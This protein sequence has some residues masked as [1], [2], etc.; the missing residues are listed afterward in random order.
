MKKLGYNYLPWQNRN[1]DIITIG[2]DA[3]AFIMGDVETALDEES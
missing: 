2:E 1:N 3:V